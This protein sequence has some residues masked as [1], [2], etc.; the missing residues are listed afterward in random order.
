MAFDCRS[1]CLKG[2]EGAG[3]QNVDDFH[4]EIRDIV[5]GRFG[6]TH[7]GGFGKPHQ[8]PFYCI[9]EKDSFSKIPSDGF[10]NPRI[11]P[12]MIFIAF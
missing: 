5:G 2:S 10:G 12:K 6:S 11:S 9:F 3:L 4:F 1:L 8:V 7:P